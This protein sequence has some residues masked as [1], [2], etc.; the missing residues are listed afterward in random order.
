MKKFA[1]IGGG[2]VANILAAEDVNSIG[3]LAQSFIT[4]DITD[5]S[6]APSVGW[7]WSRTEGFFAP[8]AD[9]QKHLL[10]GDVLVLET[11]APT[12]AKSSAKKKDKAT[13]DTASEE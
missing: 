13:D 2:R 10:T 1:L 5:L 6:P 12:I 3:S 8:V 9:N 11:P 4:V 7:G